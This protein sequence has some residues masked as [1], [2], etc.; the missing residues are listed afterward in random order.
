MFS[1]LILLDGRLAR[2]RPSPW[3]DR[4][5]HRARAHAR[6]A[7]QNALHNQPTVRQAAGQT[8]A[9]AGRVEEARSGYL[10]QVSGTGTYERTTANYVFRPGVN[11]APRT[12]WREWP[13]AR[14]RTSPCPRR[15]GARPTTSGASGVTGS[16]LIYDFNVT[17]DKWRSANASHDAA[18]VE[19][20]G[21]HAA[22]AASTCGARTSRRAASSDLARVAEEAVANQKKHLDQIVAMVGA[23]MKSQIDL[24][25]AA[26]GA[27]ER[28]GAG[29]DRGEPRTPRISRS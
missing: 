20:A 19:R 15:A 3:R 13:W 14:A 8:E 12:P 29:G 6:Q 25:H 4:R 16:Q 18:G 21:G 2:G 17:A 7:E 9:A 26:N 28:P 10:P 22:G 23:G 24:A 1:T 5:R 27:R 11:I